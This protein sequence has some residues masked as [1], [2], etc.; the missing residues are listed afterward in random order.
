MAENPNEYEQN[1]IFPSYILETKKAIKHKLKLLN[2][3]NKATLY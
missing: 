2:A 1:Q 3:V